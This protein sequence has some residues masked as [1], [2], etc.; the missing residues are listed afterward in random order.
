MKVGLFI[1]TQFPEGTDVAARLPEMV[2]QVKTARDAGFRSL[3][4]PHHW[5][6]YPMQMLQIT[7]LMGYIA[8][9]AQ[10]MTIGPNI[11][12]LPP[13]NPMHVA[14]ELASLDVMCN[15]K[16]IFGAGIG[17]REVEFKAFG[18]TTKD[19]APR[20]E[21]CLEAV[22]RLWTED[23]VTMKGSYFEL[24][25]A[26]CTVLPV[27]KP[28]P[29]VWIGANANRAIRRAARVAEQCERFLMPG[30]LVTS[31][32]RSREEAPAEPVKEKKKRPPR[33]EERRVGKECRSRWSPYH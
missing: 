29:P 15:G 6:T 13:Q 3:W 12:I 23:F 22:K 5:L 28:M 33:S 16:L 27:Q 18:T 8:A 32:R 24:D 4:F 7:P 9:H 19:A 25:G 11:L 10:G 20:F 14:E 1:N 17:Y 31:T 21:E 26:N 2:E 30:G